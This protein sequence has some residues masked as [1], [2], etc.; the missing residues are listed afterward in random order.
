MKKLA[1]VTTTRAEYGLLR[2]VIKKFDID[3]NI[4]LRL[5]VTGAHLSGEQGNTV[6]EIEADGVRIDKKISI[7]DDAENNPSKIMANALMGFSKYFEEEKPDALMVLGDRFET[8]AICIVA[9]NKRIP[10]IHIHGG[11]TT[12]GAVDEAYRHSITKMSQ[13]HFPATDEYRNRIIQLGEDPKNVYCVGALGVENAKSLTLMKKEELEDSIGFKLLGRYAVGTFHPVTLENN[14]AGDQVRELLSAID[15]YKDISFIFSKAN[16]D[17]DG[18]VINKILQEYA[19]SHE[20]FML[21]DSLGVIRYMSALK[22]AA[23]V[24]GNSSSGIIEA[25]AFGI[26][27]INIGDRQK[28]RT[29]GKSVINCKPACEDIK[30]AIDTA[31]SAEFLDSIKD[32][33]NPYGAGDT[34]DK[35]LQIT[36]KYMLEDGF[37]LKKKFYDLPVK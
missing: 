13:L 29:A 9:Y 12:E 20:N 31:L 11:E 36:K 2:S 26:P 19:D 34:S 16:L 10:I 22:G 15:S 33:V 23:F 6:T 30:K 3:E 37:N 17:T 28:G 32:A 21:V 27:T 5:V 24:I 1:I 35:I 25:P 4:E 7:L 18:L 14:T 8:M